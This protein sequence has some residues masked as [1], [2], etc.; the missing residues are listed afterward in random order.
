MGALHIFIDL[1]RRTPKPDFPFSFS[2]TL[3]ANHCT[4]SLKGSGARSVAKTWHKVFFCY[5]ADIQ[6]N[7]FHILEHAYCLCPSAN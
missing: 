4:D 2:Q 5:N 3:K 6:G 7:H 1:K